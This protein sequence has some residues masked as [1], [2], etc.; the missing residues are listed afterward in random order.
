MLTK[1]QIKE[2]R[3]HLEKAQ[4][5]IFFFDNDPDGLCSFLLLQRYCGK[6][7][8]IPVRSFPE[9]DKN[10]F[11]RVEELNADYIFILDK[12]VVSKDFFDAVRQVNIPIVWIDHHD[13]DRKT[14][15]DFVEYYNPIFNRGKKNEPVTYLCQ[16]IAEQKEDIW[17]ATIGCVTDHFIPDFYHEFL[18][19]YPDLGI[20]TDKPFGV[21]YNSQIGRVG[22]MFGFA[23]HDSITNV[24]HMMKFL[25]KVKSPYEVLEENPK[26]R[27]MHERFN[28]I[29][30]RYQK[31]MEKARAKVSDEQILFFEYSSDLSLSSHLSNELSYLFPEKIIVVM[32]VLDI[33]TSISVRGER[34]REKVLKVIEELEDATGGGHANAVGAKIRTRDLEKFKNL[35]RKN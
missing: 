23:L 26:N 11:R 18:R 31:F 1:K 8:G 29:D 15:P 34:I 32:R 12:P 27:I 20:N 17:L 13:I 28:E 3:E 22:R 14:I 21:L 24:V 9:L 25:M 7:K 2:V 35:L 10:Y 30:R 6:G 16:K 33:T 19:K 4:N 5:P